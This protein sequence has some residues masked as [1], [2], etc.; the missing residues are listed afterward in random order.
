M[1]RD[2]SV[3]GSL[4]KFSARA[5]VSYFFRDNETSAGRANNALSQGNRCNKNLSHVVHCKA[6]S[7]RI[8]QFRICFNCCQSNRE[9]CFLCPRS[10]TFLFYRASSSNRRACW[11]KPIRA[12]PSIAKTTSRAPSSS[13]VQLF[14]NWWTRICSLFIGRW[15][16]FLAITRECLSGYSFNIDIQTSPSNLWLRFYKTKGVL[17]R[18]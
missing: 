1:T 12:I 8:D 18:G 5:F 7:P 14:W 9:K 16:L 6:G 3:G 15:Q 13:T 11:A 17:R 2:T 10:C 4:L